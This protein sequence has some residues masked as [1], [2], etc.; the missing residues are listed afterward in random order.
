[1]HILIIDN[2]DSFTYNLVH[3][4][5]QFADKVT[6]LRNDQPWRDI[7]N[8][9][10]K[11]MFSPGPGLPSDVKVMYDILNIYAER[12]PILG[13]CLGHQAIAEYF[14]GSIFNMDNVHHGIGINTILSSDDYLFNSIPKEFITGR[15]HSW[16]VCKYDFPDSLQVTAVS[17]DGTIMALKHRIFDIRG[18]QFHP[19]S[20]LTDYGKD[21]IRNWILH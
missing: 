13:V 6:V 14:G 17:D 10:D 8:K 5:D 12:K 16:A 1:M 7:A 19:E 15:Y 18:V 20:V 3:Y 21:I 2:Y 9:C 11:I 4:V